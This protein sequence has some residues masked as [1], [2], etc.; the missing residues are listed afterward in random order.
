MLYICIGLFFLL[1]FISKFVRCVLLNLHNIGIYSFKDFYR[2]FKYKKWSD[3]D[4]F[5]ID[6]YVGM[7]GKGKTLSMVHQARK[8]YKQYGDSVIFYSN[9]H[10]Y[11]I[12]YVELVNF[13]Q[14]VDLGEIEDTYA[15]EKAED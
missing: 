13:Q 9:F 1:I 4:L 3:F 6:M 14:L 2:Y 15:A 10:L 12:P 7:F 11:D 5:G 8:I